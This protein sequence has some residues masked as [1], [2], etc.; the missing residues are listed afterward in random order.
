MDLS[1]RVNILLMLGSA[2]L[3]HELR[4]CDVKVELLIEE[5]EGDE[6]IG[7]C[8]K[9]FEELPLTKTR[10]RRKNFWKKRKIA[11]KKGDS[12]KIRQP[13]PR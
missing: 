6:V 8:R 4:R 3:F 13:F 1:L 7:S 9:S 10:R 5:R 12:R 11:R 2:S